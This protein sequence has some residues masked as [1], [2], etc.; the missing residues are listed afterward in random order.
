MAEIIAIANQKGGVGKTTSAVNLASAL[1][2]FGHKILLIDMDPQGNATSGLGF[3]KKQ[4]APNIYNVIIE[5]LPMDQ[6]IKE[7]SVKNLSIAGSNSNLAGAEVELVSALARESRL[8]G[9]LSSIKN[10]YTFIILDCPPSLGLLTINALNA[11]DK[12]I[13]PIQGEYYAMEGVAQF[14]EAV[15]KIHA[16]LNP[17]LELEGAVLTMFD[18]RM[19]LSV[20]VKDEVT[21]FF[22]SSLFK[23][24]IPR[25]IRLAEAPGFGQN[26]LQ[27]DSRSRGAEAYLTLAEE[28]LSRRGLLAAKKTPS[29]ACREQIKEEIKTIEE[30]LT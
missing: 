11:A 13:V 4:F 15:Q 19:S 25:N 9:A 17:K 27:Y 6:I 23:T 21:R 18:S 20:Q 16:A 12:I 29:G 22:S 3:D 30:S 24:I 8:K 2:H 1:A 26:I 5:L 7:T 10:N 28:F 14:M